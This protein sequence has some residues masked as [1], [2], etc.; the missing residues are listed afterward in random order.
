MTPRASISA[1]DR[2]SGS[3]P[4]CRGIGHHGENIVGPAAAYPFNCCTE[5]CRQP[6]RRIDLQGRPCRKVEAESAVG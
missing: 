3:V 4:H 2:I 1:N 5:R 6:G